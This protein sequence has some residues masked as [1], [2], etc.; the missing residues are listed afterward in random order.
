MH[1]T[2]TTSTN[3]LRALEEARKWLLQ[4]GSGADAAKRWARL[5]N[6]RRSLRQYPYLGAETAEIPG[7]RQ[8]VV[9]G[10]RIIYQVTLD[11]GDSATAGDIRVVAIFG[12]GQEA[13]LP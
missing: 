8:I 10:Y 7:H 6:A 9:S 11:T 4:P 3:A 13:R 12:P 1:R 2:V 5:R